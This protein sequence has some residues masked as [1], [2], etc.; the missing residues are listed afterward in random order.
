MWQT[1]PLD[2][3]RREPAGEAEC[4]P[5]RRPKP[6]FSRRTRTSTAIAWVVAL[7]P[8]IALI[9]GLLESL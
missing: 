6:L 7:A 3:Q 1:I 4:A 2:G 9:L 5:R 8:W